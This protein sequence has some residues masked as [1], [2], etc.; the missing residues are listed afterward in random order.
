MSTLSTTFI[1]PR[2]AAIA[3]VLHGL[4]TSLLTQ[5]GCYFAGGTAIAMTHGEYRESVDIDFLCAS[6]QGYSQLRSALNFLT[7]APLLPAESAI[8]VLREVRA[9]MYGVR[10]MLGFDDLKIKFEIVFESRIEL[11]GEVSTDLGVP[12]LSVTDMFAEKLLANADRGIDSSV[13][14]RDMIDL[15]SLKLVH[16]NVPDAAW[17]KARKAYGTSID[18]ALQQGLNRLQ[19]APWLTRCCKSMAIDTAHQAALY[20]EATAWLK[21]SSTP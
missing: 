3:R 12:M 9:D 10:T 16:K 14:D 8:Q 2:H 18:R 13:F 6:Q 19:H 1:R 11:S 21:A 7:L 5:W 17:H 4:D 15:L 20:K